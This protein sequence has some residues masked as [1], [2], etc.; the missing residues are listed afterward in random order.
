MWE[1]IQQFIDED[2]KKHAL[3]ETEEPSFDPR[4]PGYTIM[5]PKISAL[6]RTPTNFPGSRSTVQ[7]EP[8]RAPTI[9]LSLPPLGIPKSEYEYEH[10]SCIP[11]PMTSASACYPSYLTVCKDEPQA[12]V[13]YEDYANYANYTSPPPCTQVAPIPMVQLQNQP[14]QIQQTQNIQVQQQMMQYQ[15]QPQCE[16][17][18]V[19]LTQIKEESPPSSPEEFKY[20]PPRE[21]PPPPYEQSP[22]SSI[23]A[24]SLPSVPSLNASPPAQTTSK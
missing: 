19:F 5:T 12:S 13:S 17:S 21:I 11:V 9:Q 14:G 20:S 1:D 22:A 18:Q 15:Q 4:N 8:P 23:H 6:L 10:K 2:F 3:F 7:V 24:E 16:P